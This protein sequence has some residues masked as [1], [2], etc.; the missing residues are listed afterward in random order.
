MPKLG[1]RRGAYGVDAPQV[2]LLM[3]LGAAGF[4][5]IG[6]VV[7]APGLVVAGLLLTVTSASFLFTTL[8]GK[9]AVW[10]ELLAGL[11][12]QGDEQLLDIGCGRG[13]V[14]LMAA[15]LLPQGQAV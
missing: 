12:L 14:L 1:N 6:V 13:A 4:M 5:L 11:G 3:A 9:F 10:K 8:V 2:L 15:Q 7:S